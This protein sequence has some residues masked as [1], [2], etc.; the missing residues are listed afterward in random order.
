VA[1]LGGRVRDLLGAE[2]AVDR[3]PRR[4]AVVGPEAARG[5]DGDEHPRR[6]DRV[7]DDRVET[8]PTGARLPGGGR[9]VRAE[10][11]KLVP[12][13]AAVGRPE[14]G[15]VLDAGIDG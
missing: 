12:G 13:P 5:R 7:D 6:V 14:E 11:G 3:A 9:L 8:H 4:A 1:D 15:G 10:P 2:A